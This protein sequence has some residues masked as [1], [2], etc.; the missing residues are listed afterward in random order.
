VVPRCGGR[1]EG[2]W[3][4]RGQLGLGFPVLSGALALA[5]AG[6]GQVRVVL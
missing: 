6:V 3:R 4:G 1:G 2:V 5:L